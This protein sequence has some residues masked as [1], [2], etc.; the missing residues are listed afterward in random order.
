MAGGEAA[1]TRTIEALRDDA[2]DEQ[3]I[4]PRLS[5]KL[6]PQL[7]MFPSLA[8]RGALEQIV[9]RSVGPGGYDG[10]SGPSRSMFYPP[11][12]MGRAGSRSADAEGLIR[13]CSDQTIIDQSQRQR[14]AVNAVV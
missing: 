8:A 9:F 1:L 13:H 10:I 2:F 5:H 6:R 4:D 3:D 14:S 7:S 11:A 12:T